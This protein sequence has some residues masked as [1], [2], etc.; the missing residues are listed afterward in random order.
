MKER[1]W[2]RW[3]EL[4]RADRISFIAVGI[5]IVIIDALLIALLF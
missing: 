3:E 4:S 2:K 1:S 5:G